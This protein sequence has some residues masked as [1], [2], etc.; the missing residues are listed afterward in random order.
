MREELGVELPLIEVGKRLV[1]S[2]SET[3]MTALFLARSDGPFTFHPTETDGGD[4]FALADLLPGGTA[5]ALPMTPALLVALDMLATPEVAEGIRTLF[6]V[7]ESES[8]P[9]GPAGML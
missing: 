9:I 7:A 2:P 3:E 8:P 4:F 5:T 1:Y 6:P